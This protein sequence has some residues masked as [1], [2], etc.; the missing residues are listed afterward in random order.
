MSDE[1]LVKPGLSTENIFEKFDV[2][3]QSPVKPQQLTHESR[4]HFRCYKGIECFNACCSNIDITLTPYDILRLARRLNLS[5]WQLMLKYTMPYEMDAHSM[6]GVKMMPVE[7]GTACQFMTEEGCS[8]YEDRPT[9]CR[10]YPLGTMGMRRKDEGQMEDVYFVVQEDHCK[11]HFEDRELTVADYRKEQGVEVYDDLNREWLDIIVKKRS[12][13][14]TVGAPSG[15]SMQLF[16][17]SYDMDA[18]RMFTQSDSF[19]NMF[20]LDADTRKALDEDDEALLKFCMR[21]LKQ[22]LFGEMSIPLKQG[23]A[24]RRYEERKDIIKKKHE[25]NI[26]KHKLRDPRDEAE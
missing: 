14:P 10:Y 8:V 19:V 23:A 12:A 26:E 6:P 22:V 25:E 24:K 4:I 11:G 2:P 16:S 9:A 3:F 17:M 1:K 21:F 20:D 5:T 7:G 18:F 13:G 15:R